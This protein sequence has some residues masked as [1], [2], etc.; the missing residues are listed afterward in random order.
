[1]ASLVSGYVWGLIAGGLIAAT[2]VARAD[3]LTVPQGE[4]KSVKLNVPANTVVV[5]N[6]ETADARIAF[7][8]VVVVIGKNIGNTNLVVFNNDGQEIHN[9]TI[10]VVSASDTSVVSVISGASAHR[11][12]MECVPALCVERREPERIFES[13]SAE[14]EMTGRSIDFR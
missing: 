14:G 9:S 13:Y 2:A 6:V 5:G 10:S 11:R 7:G 8:N 4:A 3:V 1:M 12:I